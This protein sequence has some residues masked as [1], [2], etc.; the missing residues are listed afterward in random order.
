[1]FWVSRFFTI[2]LSRIFSMLPP[3][4]FWSRVFSFVAAGSKHV[5]LK[6][7][8]DE[9]EKKGFVS[10][11]SLLLP[12]MYHTA[13]IYSHWALGVCCVPIIHKSKLNIH[14]SVCF[15]LYFDSIMNERYQK[16]G[17]GVNSTSLALKIKRELRR[18]LSLLPNFPHTSYRHY[19]YGLAKFRDSVD[20]GCHWKL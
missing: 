8:F 6:K 15:L 4:C 11:F 1:M 20:Q 2:I 16:V 17:E 13:F 9:K 3:P 12:T 19:L 5:I 10:I 18:S 7:C 14:L